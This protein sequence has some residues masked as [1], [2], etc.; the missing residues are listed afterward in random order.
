MPLSETFEDINKTLARHKVLA[1]LLKWS[2]TLIM[3]AGFWILGKHDDD[4]HF[5]IGISMVI[6][7][8]LAMLPMILPKRK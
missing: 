6:V 1:Y 2:L 7:A 5:W 3:L 8:G 4:R